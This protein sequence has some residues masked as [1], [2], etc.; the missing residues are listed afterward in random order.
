[1]SDHIE[2]KLDRILSR[3][4]FIEDQIDD[5]FDILSRLPVLSPAKSATLS[6]I[7]LKGATTMPLKAHV[8][9]KPG[10]ASYQEFDGPNGSG[11]KV[12]PTGTVTFTSSDPT[13]A[14]V[15]SSTGQLVYLAIGTTT[16]SGVDSGTGLS[17]TDDLTLIASVAVSAVL[18]LT[19]GV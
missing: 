17:A 18:T 15:D 2:S 11:N 5:I 9:D 10:I 3:L 13:V 14:T 16:I 12:P 8:N 6:L 1:V 7:T 4:D 19:P